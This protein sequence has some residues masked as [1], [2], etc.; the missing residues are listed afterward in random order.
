[1][2]ATDAASFLTQGTNLS[3]GPKLGEFL[4]S[5]S[6][7]ELAGEFEAL[8]VADLFKIMRES[9]EDSG[10]NEGLPGK[11]IYMEMLDK[12]MAREMVRRG[13]FGLAVQIEAYL[14]KAQESAGTS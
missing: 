3:Q 10:L 14:Q 9:V 4:R 5:R 1:M 13:G 11:D 7:S 8:F 12:E 6:Q 2:N